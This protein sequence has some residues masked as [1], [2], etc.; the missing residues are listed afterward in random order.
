MPV[1]IPSSPAQSK[2]WQRSTNFSPQAYRSDFTANAYDR[3]P[4]P[5]I[6][7]PRT[8]EAGGQTTSK[9]LSTSLAEAKRRARLTGRNLSEAET[10]AIVSPYFGQASE[11]LTAR[12]GLALTE[13]GQ[14]ITQRGQDIS[15][16]LGYAGLSSAER[17]AEGAQ[18]LTAKGLTSTEKMYGAGLEMEAGKLASQERI[19]QLQA[20]TTIR[21]AEIQSATARHQTES[22]RGFFGGGGLLGVGL[23]KGG[24]GMGGLKCMIISSCTSPQSW[25]VEIA[26]EYRDCVLDDKTL[27]GYYLLSSILVPFILTFGWL[28][29]LTKKFLVDRFVDQFEW[30]FMLKEKPEL[31][32]SA[33]VTHK[34][35]GF[36]KMIGKHLDAE[37]W[38]APHRD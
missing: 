31:R 29:R 11:R 18:G 8:V 16:G 32:T 33:V 38:I 20:G 4:R 15:E 26:R 35:L 6:G 12:R 28:K 17:I 30:Y 27:A 7:A 23:G 37:A 2:N 21:G 3:A 14:D 24:G 10:E 36:C 13:R 19:A 9:L 5:A 34:F 22:T 1:M 25:D